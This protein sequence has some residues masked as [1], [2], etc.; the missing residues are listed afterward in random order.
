MLPY[1]PLV[2][3]W[4]AECAD[5]KALAQ[6]DPCTGEENRFAMV[7]EDRLIAFGWYPFTPELSDRVGKRTG[8][9]TIPTN[10]PLHRLRLGKGDRL[11]AKRE[12]IVRLNMKGE[13][14]S[15]E[16]F[17]ILGKVGGRVLRIR[18]DGSV[19]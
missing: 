6:F 1:R 9:V 13:D 15:R 14:V 19:E 12:N 10:N 16:T 17:Y 18:E 3:F 8:L 2:F 4:I 7:Q 5:G 11:I